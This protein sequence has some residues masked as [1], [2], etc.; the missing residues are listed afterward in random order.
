MLS[1]RV[2]CKRAQGPLACPQ[3]STLLSDHLSV[4]MDKVYHMV[5]KSVQTFEKSGME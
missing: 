1:S 5:R 3:I 2:D 4:I